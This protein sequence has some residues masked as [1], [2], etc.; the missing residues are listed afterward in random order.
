[1]ALDLFL[2]P[3]AEN[4]PKAKEKKMPPFTKQESEKM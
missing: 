1:L 4:S 2:L 3:S